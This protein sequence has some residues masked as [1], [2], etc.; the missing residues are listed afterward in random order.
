MASRRQRGFTL[1]EVLVALVLLSLT[2][3]FAFG[4]LRQAARAWQ[5]QLDQAAPVHQRAVIDGL[6]R[7]Q[8]RIA[9]PMAHDEAVK[10]SEAPVFVGETRRAEWLAP[11]AVAGGGAGL[12]RVALGLRGTADG[13]ELWF[14]YALTDPSDDE[15]RPQWVRRRLLQGLP[16]LEFNYW[17]ASGV[18][19]RLRW[20]PRWEPE[21]AVAP[22][23]LRIEAV[24]LD[25]DSG[26]D[27]WVAA[28]STAA[29][30]P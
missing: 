7:R 3:S 11:L 4:G 29:L 15:R 27:T 18:S 19:G 12:Y 26:W 10:H 25:G 22:A 9:I 14:E 23:L 30:Q 5:A 20:H 2:L 16:R 17:G 8:L 28:V 6:L 21:F 13:D 24:E 1:L